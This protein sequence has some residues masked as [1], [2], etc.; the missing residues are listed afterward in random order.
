MLVVGSVKDFDGVVAQRG[1]EQPL[2]LRIEAEMV[3]A[4][5]DVWE[6]D[7]RDLLQRLRC[8][9]VCNA[10]NEKP[11]ENQQAHGSTSVL[12]CSTSPRSQGAPPSVDDGLRAH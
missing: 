8:L 4:A 6:R 3:D 10:A 12:S 9:C 11:E 2:V 1:D 7:R 5:R